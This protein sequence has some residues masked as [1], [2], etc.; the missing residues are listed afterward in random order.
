MTNEKIVFFDI[1]GT[2]YDFEKKIPES[3]KKAIF[4]L[5]NMGIVTAIAT[6]RAPFMFKDLRDELNIHTYVSF[7]GQYVVH[8]NE[9]VYKNP[10]NKKALF[11]LAKQALANEHPIIF[12]NEETMKTESIEHPYVIEGIKSLRIKDFPS[13][14]NVQ[15]FHQE[16]DIYQALLF[17]TE[18]QNM[19][20][21]KM[22]P[23]FNFVRW[24]PC[25]VDVLP[26]NGSKAN[27]IK[28]L[29]KLLNLNVE[30]SYAFGDGL[31][32]RE[33]L[34]Y[35]GQ[36]IAMGNAEEETKKVASWV[37]KPVDQDGIVFGLE[38]AGLL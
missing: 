29:L 9:V 17:Y 19:N 15:V 10:L 20:Y 3:T 1:D 28:Q 18:D 33:M 31:N 16:N 21:P 14:D 22:Y 8:N 35:V 34:S 13:N 32:D 23:D 25:S 12:Q 24:H 27:G 2:I 7:N 6:G 11:H 30:Q 37:T 36:G 38:K 26:S 4:E 5:Q